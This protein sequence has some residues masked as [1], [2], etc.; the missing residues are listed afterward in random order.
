MATDDEVRAAK[1]ARKAHPLVSRMSDFAG[2]TSPDSTLTEIAKKAVH[3]FMY[4]AAVLTLRDITEEYLAARVV[5]L[6]PGWRPKSVQFFG[7]KGGSLGYPIFGLD[8]KEEFPGKTD[9]EIVA[10]VEAEATDVVGPYVMKEYE[11]VKRIFGANKR[12]NRVFAELGVEYSPRPAITKEA[13]PAKRVRGPT[14]AGGSKGGKKPRTAL[15]L[16]EW[17]GPDSPEAEEAKGTGEGD[18]EAEGHLEEEGRANDGE[19]MGAEPERAEE[20]ETG[21]AEEA[22]G[23]KVAT[24]VTAEV[25]T[26]GALLELKNFSRSLTAGVCTGKMFDILDDME[27]QA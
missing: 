18:E 1:G 15:N 11:A 13:K 24:P 25:A 20:V 8:K 9:E 23:A 3:V 17:F 7:P 4:A 16:D 26:A 14:A 27:T 19:M 2:I 6:R 12:V 21:K 10:L 22:D 5:P